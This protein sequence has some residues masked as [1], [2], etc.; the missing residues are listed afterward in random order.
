MPRPFPRWDFHGGGSEVPGEMRGSS[1]GR[2]ALGA[3]AGEGRPCG[4][5]RV[6][7]GSGGPGGAVVGTD[8]VCEKRGGNT[9]SCKS[10]CL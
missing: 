3:E 7:S 6:G 8:D 9:H 1:S 2:R 4:R 10:G 5:G